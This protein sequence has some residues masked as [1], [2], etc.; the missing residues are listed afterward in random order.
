MAAKEPRNVYGLIKG[1]YSIMKYL[2]LGRVS[3]EL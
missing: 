1:R 2:F 3:C